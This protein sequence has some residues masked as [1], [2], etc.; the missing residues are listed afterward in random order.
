VAFQELKARSAEAWSSAPWEQAEHLIGDAHERL[1]TALDPKP[2]ER[3][4]DVGTGAGAVAL[5]LARLGAEVTGIDPAY[6]LIETARRRA[7]EEGLEASF[8]VGDAE[9]LPYEGA[10]F[11]GVASSM[12][13]IFEPDHAAAASEVARV[14]RPGGRLGF[15]AWRPDAA[16]FPI[17]RK[18]RP[19]LPQGAGDSDDWGRE[20]YVERMLS[21]DFD[22]T[23]EEHTAVFRAES[24]DGAWELM[25]RTVGPFKAATETLEAD[26]LAE[27]RR[28]FVGLLD[29]HRPGGGEVE[30][31]GDYLLVLGKR[32]G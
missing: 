6:G 13:M 26:Q 24:G 21:E 12:G 29:A 30:L 1:V 5:R 20:D 25:A 11:D 23:I 28:E 14:L 2:G 22:L 3:W 31:P 19:P 27:F 10:A 7:A 15:T 16:F 4:L 18:Y 32:R 8:D 17:T 9:S